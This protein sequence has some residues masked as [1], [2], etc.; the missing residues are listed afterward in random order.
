M[1]I[2]EKLEGRIIDYLKSNNRKY[3]KDS[4]RYNGIRE[5]MKQ[6][7]GSIKTMHV[8]SYMASISNQKYDS[9]AFY[10][11]YFDEKNLNL[12]Y[13]MGPQSLEKIG[14]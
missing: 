13:I 4:V 1:T 5:N 7:D 11:A 2:K 3:Y 10:F 12:E 6:I 9:D 14:E 8:V